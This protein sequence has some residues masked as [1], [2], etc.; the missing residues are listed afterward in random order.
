MQEIKVCQRLPLSD[1]SKQQDTQPTVNI[2]PTIELITPTTNVNVEA[3]N[4]DQAADAHID[5]NEFYNIFSTLE[6]E[7]AES[8]SCNVDNSNMHTFYQRHQSE[9]RWTKDHPLEQVRGNPSKPVQTRRQLTIDPEMLIM[10]YL[11]K[12]SKKARILEL[13]RRHLKITVLTTYTP[14]PSM[15]IRQRTNH[16]IL[17]K[18]DKTRIITELIL[19][20]CMEKAQAESSL[21]KPN[22]DDVTNIE[23]SKEFLMEL[24]SNAYHGMFDEDVVDHIAKVLEML[25]LIK[26]PYIDSHQLRMKVF[27]LL[28]ADDARQ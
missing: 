8:S 23:L 13:K 5:E 15:K 18:E 24:Q 17:T 26:T 14:Y 10:E 9:H 28:L 7:E 20:E 4:N 2:Q 11:V 22:I 21:A 25:D 27:P 3:N 1:N 19:K 12:I 6:R 16:R